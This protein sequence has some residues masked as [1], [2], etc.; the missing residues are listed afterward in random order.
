MESEIVS[1]AEVCN[2]LRG[3]AITKSQVIDGDIPVVAGGR[4][5]AYYSDTA[6]RSAGMITVSAS[7]N[8]GFVN[9]WDV[10]IFASDCS[11]VSTKDP[12]RV[13][14]RF[15]YHQLKYLEPRIMAMQQGA[16]QK[17]VYAKD[18]AKVQ[19]ILPRIAEQRRIA[20]I[21][22]KADDIQV[23]RQNSLEILESLSQSIFIEMF[24][25]PQDDWPTMP[26]GELL[27]PSTGS[28]RTGPFGSQL[29]HS[30][31][32]DSGVVV[33]G[34][35]N[36]VQDRFVWGK[37]RYI[38]PEKYESLKRF[39]VQPGDVLVTIMGTCGRSAIVPPDIPPA[40]NTKHICC[41]TLNRSL[42]LPEFLT[43][44]F[45]YDQFLRRHLGAQ[46][47]GAVM[48]GLNMGL[49]KNAPLRLP[50]IDIQGEFKA[51]LEQLTNIEL[52]LNFN[53]QKG[54]ILGSSLRQKAFQGSL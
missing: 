17:H 51:I 16:A 21:L 28:I 29:L 41:I 48:P 27:A 32:V 25:H 12:E 8:A 18:V 42:C 13:D 1:L 34:I 23:K 5:A 37:P 31:F 19:I 4:G 2:V 35:D 39:T 36:V 15:L 24:S 53:R 44:S 7:G 22:D 6:N 20:G 30:E 9:Y 10:P 50:S 40:I 54:L 49:I 45:R 26:I 43:A 11:T 38:T 33:L 52:R 47:K 14:T 46:A 3:T